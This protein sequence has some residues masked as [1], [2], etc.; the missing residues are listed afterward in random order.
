MAYIHETKSGSDMMHYQSSDDL[1][2][3]P[4]V[5]IITMS[6][7]LIYLIG[8][9]LQI[10][11]IMISKQDKDMTWKIDIAHS[12]V[13]IIYYAFIISIET[14]TRVIPKLS[15]FTGSWFCYF[16]LYLRLYGMISISGHSLFVSMHK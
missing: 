13:M 2:D 10:K 16:A 7:I 1:Y 3:E 11:I 12:I 5:I 14:T 8:L 6:L 9:Y 15:D 4:T